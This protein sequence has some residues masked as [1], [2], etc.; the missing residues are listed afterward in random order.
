MNYIKQILYELKN[1]KLMTWVSISGTALSIFL[2]MALFMADRLKHLEI[3]PMS[4][5]GRIMTGQGIDFSEDKGNSA[6]GMGIDYN[7]AMNLYSNLDGVERTSFVK[8]IGGKWDVENQGGESVSSEMMGVDNEY[9]KI[10]DYKF[11]SGKPF[12]KEEIDAELKLAVITQ[13]LARK[14]YKDIDVEG[15]EIYINNVPFIVKGV[16]DDSYPLLQD[17]NIDVFLVFTPEKVKSY[18]EGIFG[19]T[20]VRLLLDK[21][22]DPKYIKDQVAK[23]Y[24]DLNRINQKE[25]KVFKYHDQ[26]Y[27]ST[28]LVSGSFGSNTNPPVK[29]YKIERALYYTF[30]LLLPAINLSSMT[31]SRLRNRVSEIG[32]RRAFGAKKK[33]IIGQIFTENFL[34]SVL[35]GIIGLVFSLLFLLFMSEYFITKED[36]MS[37]SLVKISVT[38]VIWQI[39]DWV[40][41][42]IA[43]GA[44]FVLN[45]LSATL[46]AWRAS[47]VQPAQAIAKSR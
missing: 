31:R 25:G 28:D 41:F 40:S 6:S 43:I 4:E 5:R 14:I 37:D 38:P 17:A 29:S 32:V 13:S 2:I 34:M 23:R 12:E 18:Y 10:Y 36:I 47:S 1:Q 30:L 35:G 24:E 22:V 19:N 20:N 39:F 42:F 44:C 3:S 45:V 8:T 26:P 21:G 16:V 9:W 11:I 33:N 27:T 46:P 15:R 7:L